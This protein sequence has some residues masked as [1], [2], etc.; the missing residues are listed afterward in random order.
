FRLIH[1]ERSSFYFLYAL[2]AVVALVSAFLLMQ[3]TLSEMNIAIAEAQEDGESLP[4]WSQIVIISAG[5]GLM[6]VAIWL[7]QRGIA[8]YA[9]RGFIIKVLLVIMLVIGAYLLITQVPP[10]LTE[11][12]PNILRGF[13]VTI[14]YSLFSIPLQLAL[15]LGLAVLLFQNIAA[16]SFFRIVYFLPYISPFVATSAVF[17]LLFS[18]NPN[19]PANQ[20]MQ[21]L[22]LPKQNWLLEAKGVFLLIFGEGIPPGLVG[23]G[24]ALVVII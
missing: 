2:M 5:A 24:L 13:S 18:H 15:G 11:A 20:L 8:D 3:L 17:A 19:S 10:M 23:P 6:G 16:K 1:T 22:G 12:D 14:M 7:W 9:D 21:T 4:I